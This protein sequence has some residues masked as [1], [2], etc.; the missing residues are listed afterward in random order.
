[1]MLIYAPQMTGDET[2]PGLI[3]WNWNLDRNSRKDLNYKAKVDAI[4]WVLKLWGKTKLC[5]HVGKTSCCIL[6]RYSAVSSTAAERDARAKMH[7][8]LKDILS[9]KNSLYLRSSDILLHLIRKDILLHLIVGIVHLASQYH[10]QQ[11]WMKTLKCV[12]WLSDFSAAQG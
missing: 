7:R 11:G 12:V 1:M 6:L 9:I 4:S 8:V 5:N 2:W 3:T 10:W